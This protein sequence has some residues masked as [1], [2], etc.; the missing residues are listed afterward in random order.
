MDLTP[1]PVEMVK[2]SKVTEKKEGEKGNKAGAESASK[3]KNEKNA[4][5]G[6]N[7]KGKKEDTDKKKTAGSNG[8]VKRQAPDIIKEAVATN[9]QG[10]G[11]SGKAGSPTRKVIGGKENQGD[12]KQASSKARIR[13]RTLERDEMP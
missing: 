4:M 12:G 2:E 9:G 3:G 5:R 10:G 11:K 7:K 1:A 13:E 6:K 8:A